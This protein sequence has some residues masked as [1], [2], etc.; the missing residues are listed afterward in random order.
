[1]H[2]PVVFLALFLAWP[3]ST[4]A[5]SYLQ[6][7]LAVH[8][9][10]R[11]PS[12]H[13]ENLAIRANGQILSTSAGPNASIYQV[14][15]Y[16]HHPLTL[17][18]TISNITSAAGIAEG[19]PDIF[20]IAS[21][22]VNMSSPVSTIP[23]SYIITELNMRG[24]I[25]LPNGTLS[26]QPITRT[27]AHLPGAALVNGVAMAHPLSPHLLVADSFRGL[28]WNVNVH[29]GQVGVTI[30]DTT[31]KG[32]STIPSGTTF[33]GV[34]GLRTHNGTMY[35]TSTGASKVYSVPIDPTG[36]ILAGHA[37]RLMA[38]NVS[39]DDLAVDNQGNAYV[40]GPLAVLTKVTLDGKTEILAGTYNSTMSDLGGPT[41]ARF[42]RGEGDRNS[43][44]VTLNGGLLVKIPGTAGVVRVDLD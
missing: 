41:S 27:A 19:K 38:S 25:V 2:L 13:F 40:A 29:T 34:N 10:T 9:I 14:D 44:Y 15:P 35:W 4:S 23:S 30:N 5:Q 1:M 28:I 8:N 17:V 36:H 12:I 18:H 11:Y 16:G 21:G 43:L 42:G 39:C 22:A 24:V 26:K 37:P 33:T 31:T 20:Y 3:P 7:E 32:A 6:P